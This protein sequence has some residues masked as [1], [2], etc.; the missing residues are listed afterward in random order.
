MGSTDKNH[1]R[2][3]LGQLGRG[4]KPCVEI[5]RSWNGV[6][7]YAAKYLAKLTPRQYESFDQPGRWWGI[8]N[9]AGMAKSLRTVELTPQQAILARRTIRRH[10]ERQHVDSYYIMGSPRLSGK[11]SPGVVVRGD[12]M[13]R[14]NLLADP[15][16]FRECVDEMRIVWGWRIRQ[17][18]RRCFKGTGGVSAYLGS[19]TAL[20]LLVWAQQTSPTPPPPP[21]PEEPPF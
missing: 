20:Q 18:R 2:W 21:P 3:H 8:V 19:S 15:K 16:P 11:H 12:V 17:Q 1:L 13:F 4:N 10:L 7:S 6:F 9:R 14:W 5:S